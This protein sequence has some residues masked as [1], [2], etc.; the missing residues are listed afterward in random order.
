MG[1]ICGLRQCEASATG[2]S[3]CVTLSNPTRFVSTVCSKPVAAA[4]TVVLVGSSHLV[5]YSCTTRFEYVFAAS[6][7]NCEGGIG[8]FGLQ[9]T[10]RRTSSTSYGS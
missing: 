5:E 1:L 4:L 2:L 3:T 6:S 7:S 9:A 8:T 10:D